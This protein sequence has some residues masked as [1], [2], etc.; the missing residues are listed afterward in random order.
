MLTEA[1]LNKAYIALGCRTVHPLRGNLN[2]SLGIV[3]NANGTAIGSLVY[4][5]AGPENCRSGTNVATFNGS[6]TGVNLGT[7][8]GLGAVLAAGGGFTLGWFYKI[9]ASV[10]TWRLGMYTATTQCFYDENPS[11]NQFVLMRNSLTSGHIDVMTGFKTTMR[12]DK[13]HHAGVTYNHKT[14]QLRMFHEGCAIVDGFGSSRATR[15]DVDVSQ[16]TNFM[17]GCYSFNGGAT[18]FYQGSHCEFVTAAR[19]FS[20]EEFREMMELGI[21]AYQTSWTS[22][23]NVGS[24]AVTRAVSQDI[25]TGRPIIVCLGDSIFT[26]GGQGDSN[27]ARLRRS[28]AALCGDRLSQGE[29][30]LGNGDAVTPPG[31]SATV[32]AGATVR[33][34]GYLRTT[35]QVSN[36]DPMIGSNNGARQAFALNGK[37][38]LNCVIG[39]RKG[40]SGI[41]PFDYTVWGSDILPSS[42]PVTGS[43]QF[44]ETIATGTLTASQFVGATS[45][46]LYFRIEPT[47][48]DVQHRFYQVDIVNNGASTATYSTEW[49]SRE[50]VDGP[51]LKVCANGG[52]RLT[53]FTTNHSGMWQFWR[54]YRAFKRRNGVLPPIHFISNLG[55]NDGTAIPPAT[56]Y[57]HLDTAMTTLFAVIPDA[58][59][60]LGVMGPRDAAGDNSLANYRAANMIGA[61]AEWCAANPTKLVRGANTRKILEKRGWLSLYET[62]AYFAGATAPSEYN[63]ATSYS[64]YNVVKSR[65]IDSALGNQYFQSRFNASVGQML[66]NAEQWAPICRHLSDGVHQTEHGCAELIGAMV[67][68]IFTPRDHASKV[69]ASGVWPNDVYPA[70]TAST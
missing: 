70:V 2:E 32:A 59:F 20:D 8:G 53:D 21:S 30:R 16:F 62:V 6:S 64:Q 18:A 31:P 66:T 17:L 1:Q 46:W 33:A 23:I 35:L 51:S 50:N 58:T 39:I 11:N 69:W 19:C 55:A 56:F 15:N 44:A 13:W 45:D 9:P 49:E 28:V 7:L 65:L 27:V 40:A 67:E 61:C 25:V 22:P 36:N 41:G 3:A 37:K 14:G 54:D 57:S 24:K 52:Y 29:R 42:P 47:R 60:T 4:T 34:Y 26:E 38:G 43:N 12:D 10:T 63:P 68:A 5:T 48:G